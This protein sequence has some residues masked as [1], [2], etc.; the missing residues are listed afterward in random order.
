MALPKF[1]TENTVVLL[2]YDDACSAFV[3]FT[4][5]PKEDILLASAIFLPQ[6]LGFSALPGEDW[7]QKAKELFPS[8]LFLSRNVLV[9]HSVSIKRQT[10]H[11]HW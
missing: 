3:S 2:Q 8:L 4:R 7:M 9:I 5:Y 1:M 10:S 11:N 6:D